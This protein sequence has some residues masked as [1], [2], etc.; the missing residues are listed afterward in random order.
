MYKA[1]YQRMKVHNRIMGTGYKIKLNYSEKHR[2]EIRRMIR[3]GIVGV[4]NTGIF[5]VFFFLFLNILSINYLVATTL[6]YFIAIVNSFILNRNWTFA[7]RGKFRK[8]FVKFVIVNI[9]AIIVNS[10]MMFLLVD[11]GGIH[12]WVAQVMTICVT[13]CVNYAGNRFWTFR[14]QP[15][16]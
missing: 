14:A 6:S 3:F 13:M 15:L 10:L 12:P 2:E 8:K 5:F 1:D 11:L 16:D 7:S 4:L 9:V